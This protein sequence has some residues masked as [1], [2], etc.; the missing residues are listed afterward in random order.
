[1]AELARKL[2]PD[3]ERLREALPALQVE[4]KASLDRLSQKNEG[5]VPAD[6]RAAD[7]AADQRDAKAEQAKDNANDP[8]ARAAEA[9]DQRRIAN[10]LRNLDAPDAP[11]ARAE[12]AHR[13]E[14][15]ADALADP[16][17]DP[18]AAREAVAEAAK[19]ADALARR[20]ADEQTPRARAEALAQAQR[21]LNGPEAPAD[22]AAMARRQH[23]IADELALLPVDRKA[24]A[25]DAVAQAAAMADR[26]AKP[27]DQGQTPRPD[28]VEAADAR[29]RAA[30][31]LDALAA[32]QLPGPADAPPK[33]RAE[34]LARAEHALA[35]DLKAA[36]DH[37]EAAKAN[38]AAGAKA[39]DPAA[40]LARLDAELAPLAARQQAIA[41][42]ARSLPDPAGARPGE[43]KPGDPKPGEAKPGDPKPGE[44][45]PGDP[46]PRENQPHPLAEAKEAQGH[47]AEAMAKHDPGAAAGDA[48]KAGEALERLAQSLPAEANPQPGQ[49]EKPGEAHAGKPGEATAQ[50]QGGKPGEGKPG[51]AMPEDAGLGI[52]AGDAA[53]AAG[54]ARRERHIRE[55]VQAILGERVA[56]QRDLRDKAAALGREVAEL[57]DRTRETSPK[58]QG[59]ANAAAQLLGHDAPQAMDR[60]AEGLNQ[61]HPEEALNDQRQAADLAEQAARN[62]ED[63]AA[64]LRADAPPPGEADL[65]AAQ[66]AQREAGRQLG[67]A[68]APSPPQPPARGKRRRRPP[69]APCIRPPGASAPPRNPRRW[70]PRRART[71]ASRPS[72]T[73]SRPPS[74][75]GSG[76]GKADADLA[77]LQEVLKAKTG[78]AWG[79]LPGHLRTEILQMSQ[80]RYRDDYARLIQLY[81]REIAA[82]APSDPGQ[83]PGHDDPP[84]PRRRAPA[85]DRAGGRPPR[86]GPPRRRAGAGESGGRRGDPPGAGAPQVDAEARRRPGTRAV[87]RGD[88]GH[89]AGG[90]GLPGR[91]ARP[92]GAGAVQRGVERGV[93][94]VLEHQQPTACSSPTRATGRCTATASA[95]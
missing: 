36:R 24:A 43:A 16:A 57:R 17:R 52:K 75:R 65:A 6:D 72:P 58:A 14:R 42:A 26:A 49:G 54:L 76:A 51:A 8:G 47:A 66:A 1:M 56:P 91:R 87:R 5:K 37:A 86:P 12:A 13:A 74:P 71:A 40:A 61:G 89:L 23:A 32:R 78:R 55:Q 7:L 90:H 67:Q 27:D 64:A 4:A 35:E 41:E 79:E 85:G 84:P 63:M 88:V 31:A 50:A 30:K 73:P 19:A 60:A 59:P 29:D 68:R 20:L 10:A 34:A 2:Q 11:L 28:P 46:K 92:G 82:G 81:F 94:Y 38:A 83:E 95:R 18:A 9:A 3:P 45:K 80:G 25:A 53:E 44:A 62:A 33:A 21:D 22:P 70:P 48:H 69:P 93:R 15:A 77:E 39:D